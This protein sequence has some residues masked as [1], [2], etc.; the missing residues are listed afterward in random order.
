MTAPLC[1]NSSDYDAWLTHALCVS[2]TELEV[3]L[4]PYRL[5]DFAIRFNREI[6]GTIQEHGTDQVAAAIWYVYGGS[7]GYM[8]EVLNPSLGRLRYGFMESVRALYSE[9]FDRHCV[10]KAN[11]ESALNAACYMLWDMDGIECPV[12][13]GDVEMLIPSLDVLEFAL[14]LRNPA[15][16]MSALHGLGHLVCGRESDVQPIL[17]AYLQTE[18][19]NDLRRYA[20]A[21]MMGRIQ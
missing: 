18:P 9:G 19:P 13:G 4:E 16:Q 17:R 6:D 14:S 10:P 7:S 12:L 2:E 15:C 3:D 11:D 8:W 5:N 1:P 20:N 21:A